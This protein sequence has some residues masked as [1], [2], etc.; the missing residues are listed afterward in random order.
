MFIFLKFIYKD[1]L[2]FGIYTAFSFLFVYF[3]YFYS[4]SLSFY[5]LIWFVL[6]S[7]SVIYNAWIYTYSAYAFTIILAI[8]YSFYEGL[9]KLDLSDTSLS[10]YGNKS[11]YW[12]LFRGFVNIAIK[13]FFDNKFPLIK[14]LLKSTNTVNFD[15]SYGNFYWTLND[16]LRIIMW[17]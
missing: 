3:I 5:C 15:K 1:S 8:S 16:K 9:P 12:Y 6:S 10:V 4:F 7:Y 14:S 2:P 13:A 17:V 11:N